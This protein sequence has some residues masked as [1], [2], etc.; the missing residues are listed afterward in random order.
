LDRNSAI[1]S[2]NNYNTIEAFS[3]QGPVYMVQFGAGLAGG[4]RPLL[5]TRTKPDVASFDG[6]T[7]S[8]PGFQPFYGTSASAPHAAGLAAQ[9]LGLFPGLSSS[10]ART[11]IQNGCIDYGAAGKD[12]VF[13][14]GR[15]DAFRTIALQ[16]ASAN[17]SLYVANFTTPTTAIPDNNAAGI[18]SA[19]NLAP[20]CAN[21]SPSSIYI[22]ITV[23]GHNKTGDL[24]YTLKSPDNTT[25]TLMNR[26]VSGGGNATGKNPNLVFGDAASAA[27]QTANAAGLEEVGFYIPANAISTAGGFGSH[28]LG[29]TWTLTASDN[30][31]TNTGTLK[32]WGIYAIEGAATPPKLTISWNPPFIFPDDHTLRTITVTNSFSGGCSPSVV[33]HSVTS[34]EPDA[35]TGGGDVPGDIQGATTGVNTTS[36]QL[37]S[38]CSPDAPF[39]NGRYYTIDYRITDVGGY[40]RDTLFAIP[41]LCIPGR[42]DPSTDVPFAGLTLDRAPSPD[43]LTSASNISYTIPGPS[44]AQILLTICNNLGKWIKNFDYGMKAPGTYTLSWNAS[45]ADGTILPNGVYAYQLSVG[46]PYNALKTGIVIVNRP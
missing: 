42:V 44:S 45:A 19:L 32:D 15:T 35:G 28:G 17:P 4:N 3:S 9:L 37:R 30:A 40:Q 33:L 10:Q 25:I 6:V 34:N 27:I 43:P 22:G 24:I 14:A 29:G 12:N 31:A 16:N 5:S 36:F 7:T 11:S 41:V 1:G 2:E 46:T 20:P 39:G 8:V 23:D 26:P 38:E 13:G 18:S 21:I